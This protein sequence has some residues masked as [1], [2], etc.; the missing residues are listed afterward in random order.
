MADTSDAVMAFGVDTSPTAALPVAADPG[1]MSWKKMNFV[2]HDFTPQSDTVRSKV[3]RPDAANQDARRFAG[4]FAGTLAME[5]A[6]DSELETLMAYALRGA[7]ASNVL[8][9][10]VAKAELVFEERVTEAGA[11]FYNRYRGAVIGGFALEVG[12]DGLADVRFPVTGRSIDDGAAALANAVYADAGTAPVL[13]GVDFTGLTLGGFVTTLDVESISI[14]LT[15][16]LR[17]DRKLGSKDPRAV[18]YGKRDVTIDFSAYFVN[19]EA[20][21]KFK[22]D[23]PSS[24]QFGFTAPGVT[25]GFVFNFDRTRIAT[26][27]KPVPGENQTLKVAMQMIATY[28][29]TNGTDFRITRVA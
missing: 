2:S 21:Q 14:D 22:A 12:T 5:L 10:G 19:N 15:N 13:A 11:P 4:G 20:L 1:N 29:A 27:G 9:A 7:W 6:R 28:D 17:A 8:K 24:A 25:A 23:A 16:N 26:Y 18:P 3:I